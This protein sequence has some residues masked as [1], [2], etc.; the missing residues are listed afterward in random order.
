MSGKFHKSWGEF[1]GFKHPNA[2]RYEAASMIAWGAHCN[3]GDQLH[4]SG[5]MD[6]TTYANIGQA[7]EYVEKI[8]D[9]GIGGMPE[10]RLAVWRSFSQKA[11]E[12]L[13]KM[14]LETHV[15]FDV[16]NGVKDLNQFDVIIIPNAPC[17]S[18]S[19]ACRINTFVAK[20]GAL[21]VLGQGALNAQS[22]KI[23][24]DIGADYVGEAQIDIDYL[25]LGESLKKD[26]VASP[27]LN[28]VPA[29]RVK[30]HPGTEVLATI[31]EPYF[32]RTIAAFSGHQNTPYKLEDAAHPGIIKKGKVI[33]FA[34]NLGSMYF[35]HGAVIHRDVF[36]KA[37]QMLH[38]KPMVETELPS[39][40]R[41]S[42]LHQPQHR[43]YVVHLMYGPNTR[44]GCCDVVEDLPLLYEV[45]LRVSLPKKVKR[46]YQI[47]EQ[48]DLPFRT[49]KNIISLVVPSFSC[50]T[51]IVLEY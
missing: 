6:K 40:G 42:L 10:A 25:V 17:L 49:E 19:D 36:L 35:D 33:F 12:G 15:N 2:I 13:T 11:D 44:R 16:A 24:L 38:K 14:L 32:S 1:G 23:L 5:I 28:Y 8:E 4:P 20:G 26:L 9:Y 47:P 22:G 21:I 50:H 29:I 37:V 27:F 46:C 51:G 31:R 41:I 7:Y 43:R 30:P 39:A 45:P 3:F 48:N 18:E 34:H